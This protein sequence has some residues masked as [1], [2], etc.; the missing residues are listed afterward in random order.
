MY[1]LQYITVEIQKENKFTKI[2]PY[3]AFQTPTMITNIT[4]FQS[5]HE[6]E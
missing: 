1:Q 3:E 2:K 5:I 4:L 6:R